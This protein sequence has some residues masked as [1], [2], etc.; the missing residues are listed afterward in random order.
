M[1]RGHLAG[2]E[3]TDWLEARSLRV[4]PEGLVAGPGLPV[5]KVSSVMVTGLDERE[6]RLLTESAPSD[7][8]LAKPLRRARAY[9]LIAPGPGAAMLWAN[10]FAS[11]ALSEGK[12]GGTWHLERDISVGDLVLGTGDL[13]EVTVD[14]GLLLDSARSPTATFA[15][16]MR[17]EKLSAIELRYFDPV[18]SAL[19][20]PLFPFVLLGAW[21]DKA[22]V[23]QAMS[24]GMAGYGQNS[25][26]AWSA[27]P[28]EGATLFTASARRR[29]IIK[30]LGSADVGATFKGDLAA[31]GTLGVR[32]RNFYELSL[33]GR[34]VSWNGA[35]TGR[36]N[37]MVGGAAIGLHVDGDGDP[38]FAFAFGADIS[39]SRGATSLTLVTLKWGPRFGL[40]DS[41]FVGV[42]PLNLSVLTASIP[43]GVRYHA[44]T[45]MSI[46][47]VG[48][49]L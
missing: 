14:A 20:V 37:S 25:M 13:R 39:G 48:G 6:V 38:R 17:W 2:G 34:E 29:A 40:G 8:R 30:V 47:E 46:V 43:G 15:P 31:G 49:A 33:V 9:E 24:P 7:G 19:V 44:T 32:F 5:S 4:C 18:S 23:D 41:L 11:R 28:A 36:S 16:G 10:R 26:I 22:G 35:G 12:R 45:F 27:P 1:V 42:S 21:L 3:A